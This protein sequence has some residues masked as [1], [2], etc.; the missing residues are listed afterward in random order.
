VWGQKNKVLLRECYRGGQKKQGFVARNAF[1]FGAEAGGTHV[2][3]FSILPSPTTRRSILLIN[4]ALR[5]SAAFISV[6][7]CFKVLAFDPKITV[8]RGSLSTCASISLE[9]SQHRT[10]R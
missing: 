1:G 7:V 5:A 9:Y 4:S 6:V 2:G 3:Q 10:K 8:Q